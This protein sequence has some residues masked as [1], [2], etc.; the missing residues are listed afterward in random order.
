MCG[1]GIVAAGG[2][3]FREGKAL[4]EPAERPGA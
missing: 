1:C 4:N 2:Q 3:V